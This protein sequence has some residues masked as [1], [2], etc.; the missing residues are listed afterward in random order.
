[1]APVTADTNIYISALNFGGRPLQFLEL[2]RAGAIRLAISDDILSE[3]RRVLQDKFGWVPERVEMAAA[4]LESFTERVRP[5][6][7]LQVVGA[8]PDDDRIVECAM[9]SRSSVIVSGDKHLL[10]LGQYE[11]IPVMRVGDFLDRPR[12]ERGRPRR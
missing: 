11:G 8:D 4:E 10:S 2:A 3:V 6:Q 9:A 7:R 12:P 1:V 5:T